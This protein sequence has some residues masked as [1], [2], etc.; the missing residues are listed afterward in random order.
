MEF[1]PTFTPTPEKEKNKESER[2]RI[3]EICKQ[4][5]GDGLS[6]EIHADNAD[7]FIEAID[8]L[9]EYQDYLDQKVTIDNFRRIVSEVKSE[10]RKRDD[11]DLE[12]ISDFLS[13]EVAKL[14]QKTRQY[15]EIINAI[16]NGSKTDQYRDPEKYKTRMEE[17]DKSRRICH[18][19]IVSQ[20]GIFKRYLNKRLPKEFNINIDVDFFSEDE[21]PTGLL[22]N[23]S[24]YKKL[25]GE[26]K[27]SRQKIGEWA[28]STG[29]GEKLRDY[30]E[31]AQE[32]K[33]RSA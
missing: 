4:I 8:S 17:K 21:L 20:L 1:G 28:F 31:I 12:Y 29:L 27:E 25:S 13:G 6:C 19:R 15:Y 24:D 3:K 26:D 11:E 23:V 14:K 5:E 32:I 22:E 9:P 30:R 2:E 7:G 33:K 10:A 16:E 18:N